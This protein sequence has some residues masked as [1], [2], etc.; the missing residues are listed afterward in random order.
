MTPSQFKIGQRVMLTTE[1]ERPR[2]KVVR[3]ARV[4]VFVLFDGCSLPEEV[5][6]EDL[7]EEVK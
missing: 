1:D 7:I 3:V 4:H 5:R 6:P 2:G